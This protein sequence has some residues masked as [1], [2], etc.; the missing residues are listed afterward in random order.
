[1]SE[2]NLVTRMREDDGNNTD[3]LMVEAADE[4]E[5]LR[6]SQHVLDC[7]V[8]T[9]RLQQEERNEEIERLREALERIH[10]EALAALHTENSGDRHQES[11]ES[12]QD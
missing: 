5:K 11:P 1:M 9:L 3:F 6:Q 8:S 12:H 10:E 7:A 4:I 2:V